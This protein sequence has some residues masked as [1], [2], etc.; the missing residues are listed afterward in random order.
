[1]DS[2]T[3][4]A[5]AFATLAALH[6]RA[7]TG[8]GQV[9]EL[10]QSENVITELGDVF[11]DLQLGEE[12]RRWG[13]R[14]PHRA[15]QGVYVC[16]DGR[17]LA[18]TVTDDDAWRGLAGV[19]GRADLAKEE[20]LAD[21]AGRQAAHDELDDVIAAW[22]ATVTAVDAFHALQAAGVAAAPYTDD[23]MLASDPHLAARDWIRPLESR[24]VGVHPHLGHPFRGIPLDWQRGAPVL[25][26][27]NEYVFTEVLGL[28]DGEYERL[29]AERVAVEDYL[30][31]NGDPY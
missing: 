28:D 16:G 29:V 11:V 18:L 9:I 25:G 30:D 31:A 15:P 20:R 4:P 12:P 17:P 8:R 1:M 21:T 3:G 27:D 2:V 19:L 5:G 10:A 22:A 13:N 7:A 14:D 26:E 23:A 24:D 6:Y